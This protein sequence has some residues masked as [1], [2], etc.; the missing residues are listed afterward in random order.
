MKDL[1]STSKLREVFEIKPTKSVPR[2]KFS[3]KTVV[4]FLPME[5]LGVLDRE[6]E[7]GRAHV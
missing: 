2:E 7:I 6:I 4:S 5:D 3:S 1:W